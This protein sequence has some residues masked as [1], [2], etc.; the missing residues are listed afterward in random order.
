MRQHLVQCFKKKHLEPF[1]HATLEKPYTQSFFPYIE[2]ELYCECNMPEVYDDMIQC[3][4]CE[5]WFN[6]SCV[7]LQTPPAES[8]W[9]CSKC[10]Y[11]LLYCVFFVKVNSCGIV[12]IVFQHHTF[13][14][15]LSLLSSSSHRSSIGPLTHDIVLQLHVH[16]YVATSTSLHH[17]QYGPPS[18]YYSWLNIYYIVAPIM[19]TSRFL[20]RTQHCNYIS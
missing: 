11:I 18:W 8:E 19:L 9:Y 4:K 6:L 14:K 2:I 20:R 3:D 12:Y 5:E 10:F 17:Q 16:I 1:P 13:I 7:G 15:L